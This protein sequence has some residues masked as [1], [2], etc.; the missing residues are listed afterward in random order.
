[1]ATDSCDR[2]G[3]VDR[4]NPCNPVAQPFCDVDALMFGFFLHPG[5]NHAKT[6][7][8]LEEIHDSYRRNQRSPFEDSPQTICRCCGTFVVPSK[9]RHWDGQRCG[10]CLN[11]WCLVGG[12]Q[13]IRSA[14]PAA[15]L[16]KNTN[17]YWWKKYAWP[18]N[19]RIIGTCP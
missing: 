13:A 15:Q 12:V 17:P 9:K 19:P 3:L 18:E 4:N 8:L 16:G 10:P 11:T 6:S 1:M 5:V 7:A 2:R 14:G